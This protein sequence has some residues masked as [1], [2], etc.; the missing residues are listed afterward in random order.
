[1][2]NMIWLAVGF[3]IST[4]PRGTPN[5]H[6]PFAAPELHETGPTE[7][8]DQ[9]AFAADQGRFYIQHFTTHLGPGQTGCQTNLTSFLI[10]FRDIFGNS[11]KCMQIALRYLKTFFLTFCDLTSSLAANG[12]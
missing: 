6:D 4:A 1:M 5:T 3:G 2:Q 10:H 8:A 12:P 7:W 9:F 11:Q